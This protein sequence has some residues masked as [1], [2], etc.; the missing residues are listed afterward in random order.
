MATQSEQVAHADLVNGLETSL[1][2]HSG[3][4]SAD[5]KPYKV[6]DATGNQAVANTTVTINLDTVEISDPNYSLVNDEIT[7]AT[8]GIYLISYTIA[9][10]ELDTSGG[11][12]AM[13]NFWLE[14]DDSGSY[15]EITGSFIGVYAR[16]TC[17]DEHGGNNAT[18]LFSQSNS[19]KKLR[20]RGVRPLS[21]GT[22]VDTMIN[23]TSVSIIKVG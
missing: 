21:S 14:S 13:I 4:G 19:N 5:F 7:M 15:D 6:Y 2:S 12:R 8:T 20:M 9:I 3:G 1:H 17:I 18:F 16:E 10:E 22:N 11:T 23:R